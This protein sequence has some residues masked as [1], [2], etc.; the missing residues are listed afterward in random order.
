LFRTIRSSENFHI[1]LWLFKDLCWVMDMHLFGVIMIVP[2]VAMAVWIAWRSRDEIG[3]LLHSVAVVC[4][5]SANSIWMIGEFFYR[6]RTRPVAA[7]FFVIGLL[8]VAW[9]YLVLLPR[10]KGA[11]EEDLTQA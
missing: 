8:C 9:Y 1:V 3:E 4:W 6:D 11:D 10:R 2:T 7:C 5:I